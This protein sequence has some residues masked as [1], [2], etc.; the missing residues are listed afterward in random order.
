M[1]LLAMIGG[2]ECPFGINGHKFEVTL[3]VLMDDVL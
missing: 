3:R 1:N 2:T